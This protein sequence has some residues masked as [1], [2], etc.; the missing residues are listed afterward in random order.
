MTFLGG[1]LTVSVGRYISPAVSLEDDDVVAVLGN[2]F[3]EDA[4][5]CTVA[6]DGESVLA[7]GSDVWWS[8]DAITWHVV[9]AFRG[10]GAAFTVEGVEQDDSNLVWAAVGPLGYAVIGRS[11]TDGWFSPDLATWYPIDPDSGPDYVHRGWFGPTNLT[12]SDQAIVI[13]SGGGA[14][15]WVGTPG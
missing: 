12:I 15:A 11:D 1:T 5:V 9:D 13:G 8:D 6:S 3:G 10:M 2:P 4:W 7:V 14:G